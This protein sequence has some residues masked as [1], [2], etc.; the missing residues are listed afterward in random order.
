MAVDRMLLPFRAFAPLYA[1]AVCPRF[2]TL[3]RTRDVVLDQDGI[4]L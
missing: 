1:L 2:W 3:E 4:D